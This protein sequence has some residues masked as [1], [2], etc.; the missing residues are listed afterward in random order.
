MENNTQHKEALCTQL[1][2]AY[3]RIAYTYTTHLKKMNRLDKCYR[4]IKYAQI[5]LSALTTVGFFGSVITNEVALT[6]IGGISSAT[7]LFI[8]LYFKDFNLTEES[9]QHRIASDDMWLIRERYIS[10]LTDFS[11]L[12]EEDIMSK[13][14]ELGSMLQ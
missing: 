1:R 10:L 4:Q 6:W 8:T 7:L 9:R 3:G 14:D 13:R 11:V 2:E 12:S 5:A